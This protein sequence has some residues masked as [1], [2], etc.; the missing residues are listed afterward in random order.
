MRE[1][2]SFGPATMRR[3]RR[4]FD[5][6]D[7]NFLKR[8]RLEPHLHEDPDLPETGDRWSTWDDA[9]HGPKPRPD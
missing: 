2:D 4:K 1:H 5:D 7:S 6:D 8:G 9:L 3:G